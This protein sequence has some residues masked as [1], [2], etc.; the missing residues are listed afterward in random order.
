MSS[1]FNRNNTQSELNNISLSQSESNN[2]NLSQSHSVPNDSIIN[3][4]IDFQD[5]YILFYIQS[6]DYNR[7]RLSLNIIES[8]IDFI[9]QQLTHTLLITS[10]IQS[11]SISIHNN[12]MHELFLKHRRIVDLSNDNNQEYQSYLYLLL[13]TLLIYT[14]SYYPKDNFNNQENC[15]IHIHSL[16]LLTRICH[17][18]SYICMDN[19]ILINYVINLLKKVSFQKIILSLFNR[20]INKKKDLLYDQFNKQYLKELIQLLEEIILLENII[21]ST[22]LNLINQLIVNQPIFLLTI[23]QYLKQ[24]DFI[25]NH[26]YI[27]SLV[28]RIL[29]HCGSA[30]KTISIRVIEQICRNLC[31]VVQ[32]HS[33]EETEIKF[34]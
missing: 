4:S 10:N 27:I 3:N 11:S 9:P 1:L 19:T 12:H 8:L 31:F 18:L 16:I 7:I 23:L 5:T 20:I 34:K 21:S 26:R 33:Q 22:D 24:I 15:Q 13:N 25:E 17:N 2:N 28:V 32:H 6:Y 29:P 14:Y 30:L